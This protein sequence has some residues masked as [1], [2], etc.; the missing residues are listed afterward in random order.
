MTRSKHSLRTL[1]APLAALGV[2]LAALLA[3]AA[4][5]AAVT[6]FGSDLSNTANVVEDHGPDTAFWNVQLGGDPGRA[7]VPVDGQVTIANVKGIVLADP[8]GRVKPDPQFH[9]Q[10]LHPLGDGSVK[11]MLS[12]AAFRLPVGGDAQQV[13]SFKPLNLCVQKGDYVDF[14]DIGGGE[15]AWGG[16]RGMPFQVF[17]R[18]PDST[19]SQYS[20]NNGTNIGAVFR[21]AFTNQGE[22][23]LMQTAVASGADATDICPG[24]YMQHV[25]TG[26]KVVAGQTAVLHTRTRTAKVKV[27]CPGPSYGSCKGVISLDATFGSQNVLVGS[28]SFNIRPGY[29]TSIEVKM[30]AATVKLVQKA[31]TLAA[32]VNVASH[33]DPNGDKH[34]KSNGVPQQSKVTTANVRIKPDKLTSKKKKKKKKKKRH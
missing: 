12:S 9:L 29:V 22:E 32:N 16:Y 8:S 7:L 15:W 4:G 20:A 1:R 25:F 2:S 27:L 34:A 26:A 11:V 5:Q 17:S 18:V 28:S 23:L 6:V 14:N 33:D 10:V 21:P 24:G 19:M 13:S 3:P 30:T 31:R